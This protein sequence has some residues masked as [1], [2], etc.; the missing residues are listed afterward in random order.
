[1]NKIKQVLND[2]LVLGVLIVVVVAIAVSIVAISFLC[3]H[4]AQLLVD[5]LTNNG[6]QAVLPPFTHEP[7]EQL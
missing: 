4:I 1:M 7:I 3:L 2:L 6:Q 5:Y